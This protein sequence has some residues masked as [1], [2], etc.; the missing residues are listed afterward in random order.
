MSASRLKPLVPYTHALLR[1]IAGYMFLQIGTKALFGVPSVAGAKGGAAAAGS[2]VWYGGVIEII[3]GTLL[4]AGLLVVPTAFILCGEMAVAYFT[5]HAP[6]GG[7]F[8]PVTN[9]GGPAVV[10]CFVFL[11]LFTA[12]AGPWSLDSVISEMRR[13]KSDESPETREAKSSRVHKA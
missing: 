9:G 13:E 7:L 12:G 4:I 8:F 1:I 2:F 10:F 6:H 5:V 3:G 11:F